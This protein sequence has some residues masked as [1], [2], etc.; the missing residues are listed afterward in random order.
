MR[1]RGEH[2]PFQS[3]NGA[4]GGDSGGSGGY[5]AHIRKES[6]AHMPLFFDSSH[7]GPPVDTYVAWVDVMGI[8]GAL[9]RSISVAANFV[10]KMHDAAL[11]ANRGGIRLY[12]VMDGV[13][14]CSEK[15]AWM[16]AFLRNLFRLAAE[17]FVK[18][19]E[20]KHKF[21]IRGAIAFGEVYHGSDLQPA[22]SATLQ[23]QQTYRDS[24]LLG[25]PMVAAHLGEP[26]APPFGLFVDSTAQH[27]A[28]KR[29]FPFDLWWKWYATSDATLIRHL[30]ASLTN[31]YDWCSRESSKI[32]YAQPR[33]RMHRG[34]AQLY[35]GR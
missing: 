4:D 33:I 19:S 13:Y 9:R 20:N 21:V 16:E 5:S 34:Q 25:A 15:G 18:Q 32:A 11:K 3:G 35:L 23:S 12:P 14:V 24:I 29:P 6:L 17:E 1:R 10:Y 2:H 28:S 31:Y 22:A 26:E 7:L 27:F 30:K 8:Q